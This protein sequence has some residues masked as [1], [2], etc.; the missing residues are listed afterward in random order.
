MSKNRVGRKMVNVVEERCTCKCRI[1]K[2]ICMVSSC[3]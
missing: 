2:C 3:M 1:N